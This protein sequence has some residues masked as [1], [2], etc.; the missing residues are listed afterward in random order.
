MSHYENAGHDHN[1]KIANRTLENVAEFK[2]LGMTVTNQNFVHEE[3]G[4]RLKLG[5]ACYYIVLNFVF[6]SA[7]SKRNMKL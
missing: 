2:H 5:N 4:S 7:V 3:F 1:I 6:G